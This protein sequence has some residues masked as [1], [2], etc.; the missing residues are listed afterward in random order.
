LEIAEQV[1]PMIFVSHC[2]PFNQRSLLLHHHPTGANAT[3]QPWPELRLPFEKQAHSRTA[4]K[5]VLLCYFILKHLAWTRIMHV[6][7]EKC[8]G[9]KSRM[10]CTENAVGATKKYTGRYYEIA[11]LTVYVDWIQTTQEWIQ[12]K[13]HNCCVSSTRDIQRT[14]HVHMYNKQCSTVLM[15]FQNFEKVYCPHNLNPMCQLLPAD[16]TLGVHVLKNMARVMHA[17]NTFT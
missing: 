7:R 9:Q 6:R 13:R 17:Y 2:Q 10:P 14:L 5:E 15:A 1:Y 11:P 12:C 4:Y 16:F 8:V 3:A